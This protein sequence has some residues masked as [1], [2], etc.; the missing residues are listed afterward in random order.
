VLSPSL[1][2]SRIEFSQENV[3]VNFEKQLNNKPHSTEIPFGSVSILSRISMDVYSKR[4]NKTT[5]YSYRLGEIPSSRRKTIKNDHTVV[6]I[7]KKDLAR[8]SRSSTPQ[9]PAP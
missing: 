3:Q 6:F 7:T 4:E 2:F 1:R 8:I 9:T 5:T